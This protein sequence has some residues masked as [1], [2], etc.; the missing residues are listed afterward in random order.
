MADALLLKIAG[1]CESGRLYGMVGTCLGKR[2]GVEENFE[3]PISTSCNTA[4]LRVLLTCRYHI[5]DDNA[6]VNKEEISYLTAGVP[7]L[8]NSLKMVFLV[9]V[10]T[11]QMH[12]SESF[13]SFPPQ[14][15]KSR[16]ARHGA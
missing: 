7:C 1:L 6:P 5:S 9:Q 15:P 4:K 12:V 10:M 8:A 2:K 11:S 3:F 16:A 14:Q 13:R